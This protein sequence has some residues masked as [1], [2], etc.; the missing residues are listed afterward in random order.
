MTELEKFL[1]PLHPAEQ[2]L[3]A[4]LFTWGV[5]ALG[6]SMYHVSATKQ[7]EEL[8]E[9]IE[10]KMKVM[11]DEVESYRQS[12]RA[13]ATDPQALLPRFQ[14]R[15]EDRI[16][17]AKGGKPQ[18]TFEMMLDELKATVK[19]VQTEIYLPKTLVNNPDPNN[20]NDNSNNNSLIPSLPNLTS[21]SNTATLRI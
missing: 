4:T 21:N 9:S 18:M 14:K 19:E 10:S 15:V 3:I 2:A 16:N 7:F 1:S 8:E 13:D 5:T 12:F 6:L 11:E 20:D 17:D